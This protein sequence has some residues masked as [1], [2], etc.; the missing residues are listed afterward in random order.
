MPV[1]QNPPTPPSPLTPPLSS[2]SWEKAKQD[3]VKCM[4]S[5]SPSLSISLSAQKPSGSIGLITPPETPVRKQDAASTTIETVIDC[6]ISRASFLLA[7]ASLATE[8]FGSSSTTE[9]KFRDPGS[10]R[11][12]TG[13]RTLRF[14][15]GLDG[16]FNRTRGFLGGQE[17]HQNHDTTRSDAPALS[18]Q[19]L[20]ASLEAWEVVHGSLPRLLRARRVR[21]AVD[22]LGERAAGERHAWDNLEQRH[23]ARAA[24]VLSALAHAYMFGEEQGKGKEN[25]RR[26]QLPRHVL[27]TW[28]RVCTKLGRTLTGRVP[29][30]DVLNNAVGN[31]TFSLNSTYFGL[32]EERL[33]S[34]LQGTME[35]VFA[36]ALSAMAL[37]QSGVLADQ[38]DQVAHCLESLAARIVKCAHVLE[39]ITPRDTAHF[40]PV[41]WI[42][43]YP[44]MG[45][46]VTSGELGNSG[47]DAP[48]FH[49]LDAF[50]GR[51]DVKGDLKGMQSD[52]RATLPAN[53]LA[54]LDALGDGAGSVRDYVAA[55][56]ARQQHLPT[57][58]QSQ[59][60]HLSAAWDG[61]LQM[62][63][64]F[65][66]RHRV[67]AVGVTGV[68]LNTGLH[69]TSSG[70]MSGDQKKAAAPGKPKMSP[71][72]M[73]SMQMKKG[74]A[75]RLG[76]RPLWQD[77]QVQSQRVYQDSVVV[78]VKLDANL[79]LEPGDRVQVWPPR[80]R[81][82]L[83]RTLSY[84]R[85]SRASSPPDD[86][87]ASP[88][89]NDD[90][91]EPRFYSVASATPEAADGVT[92][93]GGGGGGGGR[94]GMTITLTVGQHSPEGLVSSFL[95]SAAQGTHLRLRPWPA[96]R[97]R[98]PRD[99][100][101]PLV[102]VGQGSGVGPLV[103][104]LQERAEW[105]Q[106]LDDDQDEIGEVGDL[107]LVVAARTRRHV[108]CPLDSLEQLTRALPLAIVLALSQDAHFMIRDGTWTQLPRGEGHVTRHLV[109]YRDFVQRLVKEKGGHVYV[110]GS[111]DFGDTVMSNLGLGRPQHQQQQ[112]RQQAKGA[113]EECYDDNRTQMPSSPAYW[114]QL[115]EDLSTTVQRPSISRYSHSSSSLSHLSSPPASP[116]TPVIGASNLATHNSIT[117]CW[118]AIDGTVYDMTP[119]LATHPGGPKTLLESAGTIA[120]ARFAETHGGPHA[121]EIRAYLQHYAVGRL[122]TATTDTRTQMTTA[123]LID[124]LV[125]M[126]NALTNNSAFDA[127]RGSVPMYV[128]EDA[129][130]VFADGLDDVVGTLP[131]IATDNHS[132][133]LRE[134]ITNTQV[135]L[136][137][138]FTAL[139]DGCKQHLIGTGPG[140]KDSSTP[141][142]TLLEMSEVLIQSFYKEPTRKVHAAINAC[143]KG[144]SEIESVAEADSG[145]G[146]CDSFED[147]CAEVLKRVLEKFCT[148]LTSVADD[149]LYVMAVAADH[150][151]VA[152][153]PQRG[154]NERKVFEERN[155]PSHT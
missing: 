84:Q 100:A 17:P 153:F 26:P 132:L 56:R 54:F 62:Y 96:P 103:G 2:P 139:K 97:F 3:V 105:L 99:L 35:A 154:I 45:R 31:D 36:P 50:I 106:R 13:T 102:L 76:G 89:K 55:A 24:L 129:L 85:R 30:D 61:L 75:S 151:G 107:L 136:R 48:L 141:T 28:E 47:V 51:Q 79:P 69:S 67:K 104:F 19:R 41:V 9:F 14:G 110:C 117:S 126:Q 148:S 91:A 58:E 143:K 124:V 8:L 144:I 72:A 16:C 140:P 25:P 122:S 109:E 71:D 37:A 40:D 138:A 77:A 70:V 150:G 11:A 86:H 60:Q 111:S 146:I 123:K 94:G 128:Y 133:E 53:I 42:K 52:R 131:D 113:N 120:D 80:K 74:M 116:K 63:V 101:V 20:P 49:A 44:A 68:T 33:S 73:L 12:G 32:P 118:T 64:W 130:P 142:S 57:E 1:F 59:Y 112:E 83:N 10:L 22:A 108:P 152:E 115:H 90:D 5:S 145:D 27:D 38:P 135:L 88:S 34:G 23:L 46:A 155:L 87:D 149:L 81:K 92:D 147:A 78:A 125:R 66:E 15:T 119:F 43:T 4:T 7:Q 121:Q 18:G 98:Q 6:P 29:A 137:K 93:S 127:N 134:A 39:A 95:S 82:K 65:L 114:N 21:Q